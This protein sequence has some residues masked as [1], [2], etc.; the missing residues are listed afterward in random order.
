MESLIGNFGGLNLDRGRAGSVPPFSRPSPALN[1]SDIT[2]ISH[3]H[4]RE[5]RAERGIERKELQEAVKYG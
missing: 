5:R 2:L 3:T 1:T 4:G